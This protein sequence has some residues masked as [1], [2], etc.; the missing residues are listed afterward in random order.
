[1]AL[2]G[3]QMRER[4]FAHLRRR[5]FDQFLVAV[6]ERRAPKPCHAFEVSLAVAVVDVD[7]L[8]ALEDERPGLAKTSEVDVGM[9][10]CFDIAG[11]EIAERRHV[12]SLLR[13]AVT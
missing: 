1:M 13:D 2:A 11:R 4:E 3:E 10:Q 7:A 5:G 12:R 6:A 8:A 9:Y